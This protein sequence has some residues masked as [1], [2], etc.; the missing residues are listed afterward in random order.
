M[1]ITKKAL[2]TMLREAAAAQ[3]LT[4]T[5]V[6]LAEQGGRLAYRIGDSATTYTPGEAA[7]R[8]GVRWP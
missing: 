4:L 3:G 6:H 2:A 8:L 7:D 5:P 1:M